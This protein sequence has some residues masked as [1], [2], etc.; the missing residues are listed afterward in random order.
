MSKSVSLSL[1]LIILVC[2]STAMVL[3]SIHHHHY[4]AKEQLG[5][6]PDTFIYNVSYSQYDDQGLLHGHLN[7]SL[8]IH[9]PWKDSFYFN[10]PDYLIYTKNKRV[11]WTIVAN[12]GKSQ[13]GS[14][15]VYLWDH[16]KIYESRQTTEP[17]TTIIARTLT[18]FPNR[19]FAETDKDVTIIRPDATIRSTGM[20]ADLKKGIVHLL[21]RSLGIYE[22]THSQ[23]QTRQ[24]K[25]KS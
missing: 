10:H 15:R 6:Q 5:H 14:G 19:S 25:T 4:T 8:I 13:K 12:K 20:T 16:V 2:F 17:E 3:Q 9:C 21:S 22:M 23:K 18:I 11:S 24:G 1:L 7:T